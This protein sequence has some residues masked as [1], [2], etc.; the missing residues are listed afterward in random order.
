MVNS[1]LNCT[2]RSSSMLVGG[3]HHRFQIN[4]NDWQYGWLL[5][6]GYLR[7]GFVR[8]TTSSSVDQWMYEE[9]FQNMSKCSFFRI[10]QA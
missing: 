4:G 8:F 6:S 10:F 5:V 1:H 3:E 9:G 2:L 7:E